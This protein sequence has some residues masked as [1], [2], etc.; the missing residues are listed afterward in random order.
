MFSQLEYLLISNEVSVVSLC[1]L[2]LVFLPEPDLPLGKQDCV[3]RMHMGLGSSLVSEGPLQGFI[4]RS[5]TYLNVAKPRNMELLFCS[6]FGLP[7]GNKLPGL[8]FPIHMVAIFVTQFQRI[9]TAPSSTQQPVPVS[10]IMIGR[11]FTK[12]TVQDLSYTL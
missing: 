2:T 5:D 1:S 9:V 4:Q 12:T 3:Y 10:F 6:Y 7:R 11:R 8:F